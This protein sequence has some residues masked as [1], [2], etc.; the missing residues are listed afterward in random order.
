MGLTGSP[1]IVHIGIP[2]Y[3]SQGKILI[4]DQRL[5]HWPNNVRMLLVASTTTE[6]LQTLQHVG[7]TGERLDISL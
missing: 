2:M 4:K 7:Q 5:Y 3:S 6:R 1:E